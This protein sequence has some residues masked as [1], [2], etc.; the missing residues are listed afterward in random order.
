MNGINLEYFIKYNYDLM[1]SPDYKEDS[2]REE[3]I[4]PLL[5]MMGY[6]VGTKNNVIRSK[7]LVH[8]YLTVG[9]S[10][11]KINYIPDYL[12][13]VSGKKILVLDAKAPSENIITGK[14]VEQAYS[15][16]I[17]P[18]IRTE[19]F[20]LCNGKE[21]SLFTLNQIEPIF[22]F[23]LINISKYW[24]T[25]ARI[26]HPDILAKPA[27]VDYYPDFGLYIKR[28]GG[29]R[30]NTYAFL[31]IHTKFIAKLDDE[32]YTCGTSIL[33]DNK[34]FAQSIDFNNKFLNEILNNCELKY[35]ER[36]LYKLTHAPFKFYSD[37]L[38]DNDIVFAA[39]MHMV[40]DI[41]KNPEESFIPF[42]IDEIINIT[43]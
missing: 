3:I 33:I 11:R 35:K 28:T 7:N 24:N 38:S 34:P 10:Q 6:K 36:I 1:K 4:V 37:D 20:G 8:P 18:E 12:I 27:I 5:K 15:Y 22:H 25:F 26:L 17:H 29:T 16:A 19:L 41:V 40:N 30:E 21:L 39:K 2:V 31:E 42:I 9:S 13:E 14:N 23:E 43:Y 32:N